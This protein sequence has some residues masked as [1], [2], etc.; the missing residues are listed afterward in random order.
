[1]LDSTKAAGQDGL[2]RQFIEEA[3]EELES[4][5]SRAFIQQTYTM[6]L[7][8]FPV[9][10]NPIRLPRAP[11]SGVTSIVYINTSGDSVT[12][13]SSE[14]DVDTT[15]EPGRIKP[16]YDFDWPDTRSCEEVNSVTVTFTAGY[17]TKAA[18]VPKL[19]RKAIANRAVNE[20]QGCADSDH[21]AAAWRNAV[22]LL[23]WTR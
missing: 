4:E 10:D 1:M 13:S 2:L 16:A 3:T 5:T 21:E 7:D 20:Y 8:D 14:Y 17:G 22:S 11:A 23:E 9:G 6:V 12:W 15:Q 18:D 19:A